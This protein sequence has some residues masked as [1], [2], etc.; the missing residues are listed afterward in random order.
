MTMPDH[1]RVSLT[2]AGI[3]QPFHEMV[4]ANLPGGNAVIDA[5]P[6]YAEIK[7]G[8]GL[9]FIGVSVPCGE[10]FFVCA[11]DLHLAG[12][13]CRV[14]TTTKLARAITK[15]ANILDEWSDCDA[16]FVDRFF[17]ARKPVSECPFRGYEVDGIEEFL[18]ERL[19]KRR[20]VFFKA[21][22]IVTPELGWWSEG[23]LKLVS[24]TNN[25]VKVL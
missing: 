23:F 22:A 5:L 7:K 15:D 19:N 6:K 25:T 20:A 2:R 14:I 11:K 13:K 4:L 16:L 9:T 17:V 8:R 24:N 10:A 1:H 3:F 21:D 18:G 12:I